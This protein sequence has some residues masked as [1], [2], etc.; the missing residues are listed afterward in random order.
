MVAAVA[1][2]IVVVDGAGRIRFANPAACALFGRPLASLLGQDFGFPVT[3][4]ETTEIELLV[5]GEPRLVE[6]RTR[7][8]SRS[9]EAVVVASL[10]DVTARSRAV[11]DLKAVVQSHEYALGL[12]SHE[13]KN[14]NTDV[15][16]LVQALLSRWDELA[17]PMRLD[18]VRRIEANVERVRDLVAQ[19]PS[20]AVIDAGVTSKPEE[21]DVAHVVS[22]V[23][24]RRAEAATAVAIEC[25][26]GMLAYADPEQVG[27]ILDNCL[28]NAFK[29]GAPPVEVAATRRGGAVELR[30]RDCGP[31][32]DAAFVPHLFQRFSRAPDVGDIP[33][34]GLGLCIAAGLARANGGEVWYEPGDPVGACFCLRLPTAE[35][36]DG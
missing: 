15:L 10:R 9:D 20:T 1:D 13:L 2:G 7:A 31:G 30:V 29:Y 23:V 6:M 33:G 35:T 24:S 4:G 27:E 3:A 16:G 22:T 28:G 32:V 36:P 19:V 11:A 25:A 8:S 17:E 14:R 34:V 5:D 21:F 12:V 18:L 26:P